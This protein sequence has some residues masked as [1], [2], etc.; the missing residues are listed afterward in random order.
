MFTPRY[1]IAPSQQVSVVRENENHGRK[2]AEM[3]WGLVP[4]WAK[5]VSIGN[6]LI[7]ARCE[8]IAEKSSFRS[9]L[10]HRRCVI[11]AS[12][13]YEWETTS[14]GKCPHYSTMKDGDRWLLPAFGCLRKIRKGLC[15]SPGHSSAAMP[16]A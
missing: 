13:F 8:T 14:K 16:T 12:R 1:N 10:R 2:W 11:P 3:R 15:W 9:A 5:D 6:K 4:H 7:N